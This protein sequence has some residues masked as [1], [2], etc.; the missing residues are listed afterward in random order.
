MVRIDEAPR[1][2]RRWPRW[3]A[4]GVAV[5]LAAVL[6][7]AYAWQPS[8]VE[9]YRSPYLE[10][11]QSLYA[12]SP[13]ARFHY[14]RTGQ[15]S[16]VVL[17]AG[18]AQWLYSFRD[19]IPALAEHHT[20]Y[21]VDL[22]SQGYTRAADDFEY[23]IPAMGEAIGAFLDAVGV[24]KASLVG[25]SWG[26]AWSLSFVERHP[27]RVDRLVL[28]DSPGLDKDLASQTALFQVPVVGEAAVKLMRRSDFETSLRSAFAHQDRVTADVVDETWAWMSAPEA[29]AAFVDLVR[30]QD[31]A[32]IDQGLGRITARTLVVWGQE[33]QWLPAAYAH[34]YGARVPGAEVRVVP[35]AGHNVHED[36]PARV[37]PL[38]VEFLGRS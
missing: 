10:R 11:V 26:G 3:L 12:D 9:G 16:P 27:E 28:M 15:G 8:G 21:A 38:L 17:V 34:E 22:P 14:T 32:P 5:L 23:T 18:G 30:S 36:D 25:H 24:E 6:F 4:A 2:T 33:D 29:R 35:G 31:Y 13:V 20:V 37:N 19:T 7:I 1:T